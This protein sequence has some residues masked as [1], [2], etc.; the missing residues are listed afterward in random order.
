MSTTYQVYHWNVIYHR[1]PIL[2]CN[3]YCCGKSGGVFD[4]RKKMHWKPTTFRQF[5][6][7]LYIN[8]VI[9]QVSQNAVISFVFVATHHD[10]STNWSAGTGGDRSECLLQWVGMNSNCTG[11]GPESC[12]CADLCMGSAWSS[13]FHTFRSRLPVPAQ[14]PPVPTLP[15][16]DC[17][18]PAQWCLVALDTIIVLP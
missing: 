13:H 12:P 10:L 6:E 8:K 18:V 2:L 7:V 1:F 16:C 11:M 4:S 5:N 14:N 17:T 9:Q 3:I 15:P